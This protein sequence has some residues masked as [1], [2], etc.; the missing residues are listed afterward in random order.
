MLI[1]G[2]I[3]LPLEGDITGSILRQHLIVS[4]PWKCTDTEEENVKDET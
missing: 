4:L 3:L 2:F 1:K